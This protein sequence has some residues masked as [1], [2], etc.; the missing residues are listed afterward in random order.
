MTCER[1]YNT[2]HTNHTNSTHPRFR[3]VRGSIPPEHPVPT[4]QQGRGQVEDRLPDVVLSQGPRRV[5]QMFPGQVY[6]L[7]L[8]RGRAIHRALKGVRTHG[9]QIRPV[10]L[11]PVPV[12]SPHVVH[13]RGSHSIRQSRCGP[14]L[15]TTVK[16][17]L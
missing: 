11:V 4:D 2:N 13:P 7:L 15:H 8:S 9:Y 5:K 1:R 10:L 17:E 12:E 3:V 14:P 6:G 16:W